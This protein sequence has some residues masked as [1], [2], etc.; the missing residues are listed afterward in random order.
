MTDGYIDLWSS[1]RA[2]YATCLYWKRDEKEKDLS[3][4][5]FKRL[6]DGRF[7]AKEASSRTLG[8]SVIGGS[9][10]ID[11]NSVTLETHDRTDVK[12]EDVVEYMGE[13]W[14]VRDVQFRTVGK[15]SQLTVDRAYVTYVTMRR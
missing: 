7:T 13:R 8:E 14:I 11:S 1:R 10:M 9:F 15:R 3:A 5:D 6:P 12:N 4:L 2:N